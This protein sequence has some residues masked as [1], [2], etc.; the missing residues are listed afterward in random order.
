VAKVAGLEKLTD[1]VKDLKRDDV[2]AWLD[3]GGPEDR[4]RRELAAATFALE[5]ARTDEWYEWKSMVGNPYGPPNVYWMP[6]PLLIEWGC[7]LL[8]AHAEPLAMERTW[9]LAA[10]SVAER[11]EDTQ[12]LV[13]FTELAPGPP[14]A[15]AAGAQ[16]AGA[17]G[18]PPVPQIS[19]LES[20][21]DEV[22]NVKKQIEHLNHVMRR[23]P[24]EMRFVLGRPSRANG[25]CRP[26]RSR[27]IKR[28]ST[29]L[30]S[31]R[32]R[33]CASGPSMPVMPAPCRWPCSNSIARNG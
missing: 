24:G 26:M 18:V 1:L 29:I 21:A 7:E 3:A 4:D 11:S 23:F 14:P 2:K 32:K 28:C 31:A 19:A 9:Q 6:P 13:G 22:S 33:P 12:F 16:A 10:M 8:R 20:F 30:M 5:A 25:R 15:A 27:S 17:P